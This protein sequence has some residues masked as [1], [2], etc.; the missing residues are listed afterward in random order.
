MTAKNCVILPHVIV[1]PGNLTGYIKLET[2]LSAWPVLKIIIRSPILND[3]RCCA[4]SFWFPRPY[5]YP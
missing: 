3:G 4:V 5:M 2:E 1:V